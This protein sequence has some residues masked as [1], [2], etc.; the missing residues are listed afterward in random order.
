MIVVQTIN[1]IE[2]YNK[3][4]NNSSDYKLESISS[5]DVNSVN[6]DDSAYCPLIRQ[7]Y[8]KY[9][10]KVIEVELGLIAMEDKK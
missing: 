9:C 6:R 1:Q 2:F 8:V 7:E 3:F 10:R 5:S 4:K